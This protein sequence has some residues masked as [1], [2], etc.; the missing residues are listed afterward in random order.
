MAA[1]VFPHPAVEFYQPKNCIPKATYVWPPLETSHTDFFLSFSPVSTFYFEIQDD[2]VKFL[3][4]ECSFVVADS[5]V[6]LDWVFWNNIITL[7]SICLEQNPALILLFVTQHGAE[8]E[9]IF[10]THIFT[11]PTSCRL[12]MAAAG[13]VL[14]EHMPDTPGLLDLLVSVASGPHTAQYPT[15]TWCCCPTV[16][17]TC[18]CSVEK[19][20]YIWFYTFG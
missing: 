13:L 20:F 14:V 1:A 10:S 11:S 19:P 17:S 4:L 7:P 3:T 9:I 5:S 18:P 16:P 6:S 12:C 15:H 8:S 2:A